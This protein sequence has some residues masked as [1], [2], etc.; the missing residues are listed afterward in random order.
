MSSTF[1][2]RRLCFP[3]QLSRGWANLMVKRGS[4]RMRSFV[5]RLHTNKSVINH[6]ASSV[7][8]I[9]GRADIN[10]SIWLW[11]L[12]YYERNTFQLQ[13]K[14][15]LKISKGFVIFMQ[16]RK[17]GNR[18][19]QI[20]LRWPTTAEKQK[21][22]TSG[23]CLLDT[24]T[25]VFVY[26]LAFWKVMYLFNS[27]LYLYQTASCQRR[28]EGHMCKLKPAVK[29]SFVLFYFSS[30]SYT[31]PYISLPQDLNYS[32]SLNAKVQHK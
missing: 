23:P 5:H 16:S 13:N 2:G 11:L 19:A 27:T 4:Y 30:F 31:H 12:K 21:N 6:Q 18:L 15:R 20:G 7:L 9:S 1:P 22:K 24:N 8:V 3:G 26:F 29:L 14:A 28:F 32:S 10:N 25:S 17:K